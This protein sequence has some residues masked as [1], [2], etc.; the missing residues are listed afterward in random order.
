MQKHYLEKRI[1]LEFQM[2]IGNKRGKGREGILEI[3]DRIPNHEEIFSIFTVEGNI[4]CIIL[5]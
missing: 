2:I 5:L 1:N 4:T 3:K